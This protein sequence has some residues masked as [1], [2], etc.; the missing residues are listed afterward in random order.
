MCE[1]G[2][3]TSIHWA[4]S[5]GPTPM[6]LQRVPPFLLLLSKVS[7]HKYLCACLSVCVGIEVM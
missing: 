7:I 4:C 3:A 6:L 2:L 1:K 5:C